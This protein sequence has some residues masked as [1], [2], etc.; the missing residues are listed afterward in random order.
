MESRTHSGIVWH[1]RLIYHNI[2][3]EMKLPRKTITKLHDEKA[4]PI[5]HSRSL[6]TGK[7]EFVIENLTLLKRVTCFKNE[8]FSFNFFF[9]HYVSVRL[10]YF[11]HLFSFYNYYSC[12]FNLSVLRVKG[13]QSQLYTTDAFKSCM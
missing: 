7:S 2:K 1:A 11:F 12:A 13:K 3:R 8:I 10:L 6:F 9:V 5:L 4:L